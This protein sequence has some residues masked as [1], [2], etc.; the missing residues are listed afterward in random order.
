MGEALRVIHGTDGRQFLYIYVKIYILRNFQGGKC[1]H[2]PPMGGHVIYMLSWKEA[3]SMHSRNIYFIIIH[4]QVLKIAETT[5]TIFCYNRF[6]CTDLLCKI[7][8][9]YDFFI[10]K[11]KKIMHPIY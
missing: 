9:L 3:N 7:E 11:Y 5:F 4:N 6:A 10:D 1:P 2:C 8:V